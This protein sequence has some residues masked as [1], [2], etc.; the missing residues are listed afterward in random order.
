M[1]SGAE[2][3]AEVFSD[4]AS[5]LTFEACVDSLASALAATEAGALRLELCDGLL[6]GG[7]TPSLGK[8]RLI[9]R[10]LPHIRLH[11]LVR[12]RP[13][14]FCYSEDELRCIEEDVRIFAAEGVDGVVVGF[15]TEDGCVD[16]DALRRCIAAATIASSDLFSAPKTLAITF[17]RAID[18]CR[19]PMEALS[20]A[21]RVG[22]DFILTSGGA[23]TALE[24]AATIKA[25][26][27]EVERINAARGAPSPTAGKGTRRL[28]VIAGGGVTA[29]TAKAI[30]AATGVRE[31]HGTGGYS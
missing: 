22:V 8:V 23:A 26:V 19:D 6:D 14:D 27:S 28:T 15:L 21:A 7:I 4:D 20:V 3:M 24:G 18:V 5:L 12:P 30:V 2:E 11:V 29:A 25:L 31:L 17:H 9:R 13:G 16:E 10:A 1:S